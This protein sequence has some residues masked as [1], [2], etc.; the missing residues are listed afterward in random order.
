VPCL[1]LNFRFGNNSEES[2]QA[3]YI[4]ISRVDSSE[5]GKFNNLFS[6]V[7][8]LSSIDKLRQQLHIQIAEKR[9]V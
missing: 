5:W 8:N 3:K 9:A 2:T 6:L 4:N 1:N 7:P